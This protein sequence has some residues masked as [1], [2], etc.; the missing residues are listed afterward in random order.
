MLPVKAIHMPLLTPNWKRNRPWA[1]ADLSILLIKKRK[2]NKQAKKKKNTVWMHAFF[3][4]VLRMF[5]TFFVLS[6]GM[7]VQ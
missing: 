1:K 7:I 6:V 4:K 2:G 5:F 3:K